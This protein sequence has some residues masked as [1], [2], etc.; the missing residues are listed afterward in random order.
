MMGV[1]LNG[2]GLMLG[3]N[4]SVVLN[5]TMPNSILKKKHAA[6]NYHRVREAITGGAVILAHIPSD[7]NYADILTK[8]LSG[9]PF[10]NLVRPLLFRT[11]KEEQVMKETN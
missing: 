1:E 6:C 10:M 3:D 7:Y 4:N 5:C 9:L 2:P 11:P 8:P